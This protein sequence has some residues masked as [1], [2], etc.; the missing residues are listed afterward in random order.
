MDVRPPGSDS[1]E[2]PGRAVAAL[3]QD[4]QVHRFRGRTLTV[5]ELAETYGLTDIDD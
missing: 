2:F 1:V 4:P 5:A 3:P